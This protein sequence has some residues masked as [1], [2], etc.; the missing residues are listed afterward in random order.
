M[1]I[2]EMLGQS[3]ILAV[4]GVGIVFGFLIILVGVISLVGKIVGSK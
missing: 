3:A 1:T 2:S 4:L